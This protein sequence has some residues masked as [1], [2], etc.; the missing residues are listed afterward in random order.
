MRNNPTC[1][2][3]APVLLRLIAF[4]L[5]FRGFLDLGHIEIS[6]SGQRTH[7]ADRRTPVDLEEGVSTQ[8]PVLR[9]QMHVYIS[10]LIDSFLW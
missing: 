3:S 10:L 9:N 8:L 6:L 5:S 1:D 2:V 7:V 4:W